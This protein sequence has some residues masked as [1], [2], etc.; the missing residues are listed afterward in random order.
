M[1]DVEG[2]GP[3]LRDT[4]FIG[5]DRKAGFGDFQPT[6]RMQ[7]GRSFFNGLTTKLLFNYRQTI[8]KYI[9]DLIRMDLNFVNCLNLQMVLLD[10]HIAGE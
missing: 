3:I 2:P 6:D 9:I 1:L 5:I 4:F 8:I 10:P 7:R